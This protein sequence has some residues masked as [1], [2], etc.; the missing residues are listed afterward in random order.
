[1]VARSVYPF[2][3]VAKVAELIETEQL[4]MGEENRPTRDRG[5]Y[6]ERVEVEERIVRFHVEREELATVVRL[7]AQHYQQVSIESNRM[8][9]QIRPS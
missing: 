9:P 6:L 5:S 8:R 4:T 3:E 1:M 7:L 2:A